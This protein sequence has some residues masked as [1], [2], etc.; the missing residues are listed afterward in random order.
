[1]LSMS[2]VTAILF[3]QNYQ[4]CFQSI[5]ASTTV[6]SIKVENLTQGTSLWLLG[7]DILH[8]KGNSG[9]KDQNANT[10]LATINPTP[11]PGRAELL[12]YAKQSGNIQ[13]V[14]IDILG[15][16]V[17]QTNDKLQ[18]G[19]HKYELTGFKEGAYFININGENYHYNVK[20]ISKNSFQNN[21][22]IK[23]LG[24]ID[25]H[26]VLKSITSIVDMSY[27]TGDHLRYTGYADSFK[28]VVNDIPTSSKII[29]FTFATLP[30][31][32][33]NTISLITNKTATGGGDVT[34]DGWS[35][36]TSRG[37][38]FATI[39]NPTTSSNTVTA[40]IGTG[41]F[42]A[43][44]SGLT[45]NTTYYVR[46]YATNS[47]GTIYGNQVNFKTLQDPV[48][49]TLTTTAT[50]TITHNSATSG[51]HISS[52][53]GAPVTARGVCW[54][55]LINPTITGSHTNDGTDTGSFTSIITGLIATT[56]YFIR[57]YATNSAGTAYGNQISF[58]TL[59]APLLP[60]LT[61]TAT[62]NIT[63]NT[64]TSGGHITNDGGALITARGVCWSYLINPTI[65]DN[66]TNDGTDT[67]SYSSSITGLTGDTTYYIRAYATN[68]AGT[69]YGNLDNFTTLKNPVKPTLIT[70]TAS[71]IFQ[72]S[73]LSGGII[74]SD[75]GA[76]VTSYGVCWNTYIKPDTTNSHTTCTSS[77]KY[78]VSK[79]INLKENTHYYYRAYAINIVG[80]TYGIE[81]DFKTL[82]LGA[83]SNLNTISV[84]N[85]G[86]SLAVVSCHIANDG[87]LPITRGVCWG[88]SSN[89]VITGNHTVDGTDTGSFTS[90]ITG[91]IPNNTYYIR[92]YA[93]NSMG[94][95][96]GNQLSYNTPSLSQILPTISSSPPVDTVTD[97]T[98]IISS[99]II[100]DGNSAVTARGVCWSSSSVNPV[101]SDSHTV[102]GSGTG[103][104]TSTMT[105]LKPNTFY[106]IGRYATNNV[107]TAY[108]YSTINT[109]SQAVL[110]T[111]ITDPVCKTGQTTASTGGD[112]VE[113]GGG[114]TLVTYG[115][116]WSTSPNPVVSG[117]HTVDGIGG[118]DFFTS[119]ITRLMPN[120]TYHIR[121][122]AT[123]SVG[124]SYGNEIIYFND[125]LNRPIISTNSVTNIGQNSAISG[126]NITCDGGSSITDRGVCW[127]TSPNPDISGSHTHVGTGT[128]SFTSTMTGLTYSTTYY[129]R[130]YAINSK[131]TTYGNQLIFTTDTLATIGNSYQG[132][133]CAYIFV[134]GDPG[135]IAGQQHGLIA[136]PSDQST[137][138]QWFNGSA[139]TTGATASALGTGYSNTYKI[140][141]VQGSGSYAASLCNNL[142]LGGHFDWYLPS[143]DELNKL[144]LNQSA[145]G[146]FNSTT[147]YW[148]STE[149]AA[150]SAYCQMFFNG[151]QYIGLKYTNYHV[152]AVREF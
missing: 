130:A 84:C 106:H 38:C 29:T 39:I 110:P 45:G 71:N 11:M 82:S 129:V 138:I 58:K 66:H 5:G 28:A 119:S 65:T 63:R 32:T 41:S 60:T 133:I 61:T 40:G 4:I 109:T 16:K 142:G 120:S 15:K 117:N 56:T 152:R 72:H 96:Y 68:S 143:K 116:C 25:I 62:R 64:A 147:Y 34:S 46:A 7:T 98:A 77:T 102:D 144:Y 91:L 105:G 3:S 95:T 1:M 53:G 67:G 13:I 24:N 88:T 100:C 134:P 81:N 99:I 146:G 8:L 118:P 114:T 127:S 139:V 9:I 80:I 150:S 75:G 132:G 93:T 18:K 90:N 108:Y 42:V 17:I 79:M 136:A 122:Y 59:Q 48:L 6:D 124:T 35:S 31:V 151:N 128:G 21:P 49:P 121:A 52:D 137:G 103:Y 123:N 26:T 78:F 74:S 22:A 125:S 112:V 37:I 111:V 2:F 19:A 89:P 43:N 47:I 87:G 44:M 14:I 131:G 20:L 126:G 10:D 140:I 76:N 50:K 149:D 145:I 92:A 86:L 69:S 70:Q 27:N 141:T 23:Y 85:S 101:V 115:V 73:A 97:D 94:T 30:S 107:G 55:T 148:S 51:G 135:Y 12:F 113:T 54:S 104:F 57:A 36:I 33:T 83:P